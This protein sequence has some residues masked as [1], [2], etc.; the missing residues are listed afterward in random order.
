MMT[1]LSCIVVLGAQSAGLAKRIALKILS[2]VDADFRKIAVMMMV[3]SLVFSMWFVNTAIMLFMMKV[4]DE[5]IGEMKDGITLGTLGEEKMYAW[6]AALESA[7]N[8]EINVI[9]IS[10]LDEVVETEEVLLKSETH[11]V[12]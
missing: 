7:D 1:F 3:I 4:I 5:I 12:C 11:C 8:A 10:T 9:K 2:L 6:K